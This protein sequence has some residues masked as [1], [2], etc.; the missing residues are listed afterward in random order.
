M[1]ALI[2]GASVGIGFEFAD[3]LASR[4]MDLVLVARDKA[5]LDTISRELTDRYQ[6]TVEV[7]PADL[8]IREQLEL[9]A[10]RASQQDI[11][12]VVNNAGFGLNESFFEDDVES[13]QYL[14]DVLVIAVMRITHAAMPGMI[15]RDLG[16]VINVS[17]I[18]GWMT[19]GTYSATKSWVTTFSE[20]LAMQLRDSK[21]NVMAVCPGYT[22]TEFHSRANMETQTIPNWMWLDV[23]AVVAKSLKDFKNGKAISVP[24]M[25]YKFLSLIAQY[26]P[27]PIVRKLSVASRR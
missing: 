18:A 19:S 22:R 24:G 25:Q 7:L 13:E 14:L 15:A 26:L 10:N 4:G 8:A 9:V 1:T 16:G 20:S 27:R 6:I 3:E 5:R 11:E 12:L 23:D 21:V 17:S 2:T